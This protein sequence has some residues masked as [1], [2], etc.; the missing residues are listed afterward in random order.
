MPMDGDRVY[1]A[2]GSRF[3][4]LI[5]ADMN[6]RVE[7]HTVNALGR[8]SN[9]PIWTSQLRR[10]AAVSTPPMRVEGTAGEDLL[11]IRVEPSGPGAPL[12]GTLRI[13]HQ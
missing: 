7:V 6:G 1:L 11:R 2:S 10:G 13:V 9:G 3:T 8:P 12:E 4:V 5:D